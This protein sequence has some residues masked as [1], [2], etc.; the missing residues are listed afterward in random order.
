[1][2]RIVVL[3]GPRTGKTTYA[4]KLAK[5]LGV[6]LASTGKH[7][8]DPEGL[9]SVKNYGKVSTDDY[10]NRYDY[11][12]LP[13]R[14]I[15]DLRKMDS[16]VLEGTQAARVLRRWLREAPE[17]PKLDNTLVF[18]G[19][20]WV[21]RNPRQEAT[22]KGVKTVWR[23]LEPLLKRYGVPYEHMT[24]PEMTEEDWREH[25]AAELARAAEEDRGNPQVEPVDP[26]AEV[27]QDT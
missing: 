3:G 7:T 4:T 1:M 26:S 23:D 9:V 8:E 14:V 21:P 20:P 24:P 22:T 15:D 27:V 2:P 6:H 5:Q 16:F 17:E 11:K 19:K 13:S 25:R 10:L 12:E 18:L